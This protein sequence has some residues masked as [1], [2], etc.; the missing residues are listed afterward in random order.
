MNGKLRFIFYRT[1]NFDR[2][3]D[4]ASCQRIQV[5]NYFSSITNLDS[6]KYQLIR[7]QKVVIE[8][9]NIIVLWV[10]NIKFCTFTAR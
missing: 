4:I 9:E 10:Q 5:N 6:L 3:F 8:S 2:S 7:G 1:E